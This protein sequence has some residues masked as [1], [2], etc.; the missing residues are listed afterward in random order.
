[1]RRVNQRAECNPSD[2]VMMLMMHDTMALYPRKTTASAKVCSSPYLT[3]RTTYWMMQNKKKYRPV[4]A[5]LV[6]D[7]HHQ[8]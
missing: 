5:L 8:W 6:S 3:L 7:R 4:D 1:M 2:P